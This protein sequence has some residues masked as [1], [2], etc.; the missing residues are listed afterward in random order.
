MSSH[1]INTDSHNATPQKRKLLLLIA[2]I[3]SIAYFIY[4]ISYFADI[5][6]VDGASDAEQ[7]G[8]AVAT[9]LIVP[10]AICVGLALIFNILAWSL[11]GAG[12]ALTAGI[13]YAIGGAF[14]F[15]YFPFVIVQMILCFIGYSKTKKEKRYA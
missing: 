3:L 14:M 9:L 11:R 8:S 13:F 2:A 6:T 5:N 7:V 15:I 4:L 12:F 10:H 1:S